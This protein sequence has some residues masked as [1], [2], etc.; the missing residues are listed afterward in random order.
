MI[1]GA[2]LMKAIADQH[3]ESSPTCQTQIP[4]HFPGG[5]RPRSEWEPF[6]KQD[7]ESYVEALERDGKLDE[8]LLT[9]AKTNMVWLDCQ[10]GTDGES[11]E[12][13]TKIEKLK[14]RMDKALNTAN[15]T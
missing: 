1:H 11:V 9:I 3:R 8:P 13:A 12:F 10:L 6:L 2:Q 4:V 14:A 7:I 5:F 15:T